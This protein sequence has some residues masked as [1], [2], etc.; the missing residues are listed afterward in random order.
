MESIAD[1]MKR[2]GG[3]RVRPR[4]VGRGPSFS[5][6]APRARE[7]VYKEW[8]ALSYGAVVLL[9]RAP[10]WLSGQARR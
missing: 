4:G 10:L 7:P 5:A 3:T 8:L 2:A 9:L 6:D 1:R